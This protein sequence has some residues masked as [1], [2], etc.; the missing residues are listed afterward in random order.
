MTEV[1]LYEDPIIRLIQDPNL[2]KDR[3]KTTELL[4]IINGFPLTERKVSKLCQ[5]CFSILQTLEKL[6]L[7]FKSWE[8]LSL[9]FNSDNHFSSS[10]DKIKSF[11]NNIADKVIV[12]C[13]ELN[14]KLNKITADLDHITKAS[15]TLTPIEFISDSGTLLTSLVL[16]NIK[17]K[18]ESA[19]NLTISYLKAKLI[20]IGKEL[21]LMLIQTDDRLTI[22]TYKN[23]IVS[24]L[25]QLNDAIELDDTESK[26]E[27]LAVVNDM[28]KMFDAFKLEKAREVAVYKQK[29][30]EENERQRQLERE[31][32]QKRAQARERQI[33]EERAKHRQ[34][35]EERAK[36][37]ELDRER[38][39]LEEEKIKLQKL[40][41]DDEFVNLVEEFKP[42][43]P[44]PIPT[45]SRQNH[46]SIHSSRRESPNISTPRSDMDDVDDYDYSDSE[47]GYNSLY[48]S[49]LTQPPLI[50]S[51]TKTNDS[52]SSSLQR[53]D[54][55]SSLSTSTL[56]HKTTISDELPYLMTA[57]SSA[58]N[59]EE[60]V[61]H[62]KEEEEKRTPQLKSQNK[63]Q[64]KLSQSVIV[65][66]PRANKIANEKHFY[67]HKSHLPDTSLYSESVLLNRSG[68]NSS[69]GTSPASSYLFSNN[70]LLSKLGIKP[71]VITT[72][73]P[74]REMALLGRTNQQL[75]QLPQPALPPATER[76]FIKNEKSSPEDDSNKEN[77]TRLLTPLTKANLECH[78]FSKLAVDQQFNDFVE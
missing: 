72:E 52:H 31:Q 47:V 62:F 65:E 26:Y 29:E 17:L 24:L 50:H 7:S 40:Q 12:V 5:S 76:L 59:F 43:N 74:A 21:E 32:E 54:S 53:R 30:N 51:I 46:H 36:H 49:T 8:F 60:D 39:K 1:E 69:P 78:T 41:R 66:G 37:R 11:N 45:S 18:N 33:E 6:S 23:F 2:N 15:R 38:T 28:E 48:S 70:S 4:R 13:K 68:G 55:I 22:L 44:I 16:R 14:R 77:Q 71:Q 25:R 20:I 34:L 63:I 9:D 35:E 56:L 67:N 19:E 42:P 61:S 27:C 3:A 75:K 58:K 73:F 10:D 57:F 64:S